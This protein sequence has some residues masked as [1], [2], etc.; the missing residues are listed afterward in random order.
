MV[1]HL[2]E[3]DGDL[4]GDGVVEHAPEDVDVR[5]GVGRARAFAIAS[6]TTSMSGCVEDRCKPPR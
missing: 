1:V 5:A 4:A 2:R 6:P 3:V